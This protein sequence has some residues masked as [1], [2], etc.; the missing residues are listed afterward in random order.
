MKFQKL[1]E[2]YRSPTL[3]SSKIPVND[4][5]YFQHVADLKLAQVE[6]RHPQLDQTTQGLI[7]PGLGSLQGQG[8]FYDISQNDVHDYELKKKKIMSTKELE[9]Q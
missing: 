9:E 7:Q 2:V 1:H 5:P 3:K 4:I 6:Q 8:L